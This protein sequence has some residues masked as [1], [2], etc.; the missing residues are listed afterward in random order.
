MAGQHGSVLQL[1]DAL[2][3]SK[4]SNYSRRSGG[5]SLASP[6]PSVRAGVAAAASLA[7]ASSAAG[8]QQAPQAAAPGT[9]LLEE[10]DVEQLL[11]S[12]GTGRSQQQGGSKSPQHRRAG[13]QE[14]FGICGDLLPIQY[15]RGPSQ[16]GTQPGSPLARTQLLLSGGGSGYRGGQPSMQ[17]LALEE[18]FEAAMNA[19]KSSALGCQQEQRQQEGPFSGDDTVSGHDQGAARFEPHE[20]LPAALLASSRRGVDGGG[21]ADAPGMGS[22]LGYQQPADEDTICGVCL[23]AEVQVLAQECR[24]G[25]CLTCCRELVRLHC[26]RPALCPFCRS[27]ICGFDALLESR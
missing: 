13:G 6:G 18:A 10:V 21:I 23:D 8:Q 27:V 24:H 3:S 16:H 4:H 11:A 9:Y 20:L 7:L 2:N 17:D 12:I 22:S 5:L 25:L 14:P 26:L 19:S 1:D 15:T